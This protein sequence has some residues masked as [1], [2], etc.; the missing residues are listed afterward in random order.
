MSLIDYFAIHIVPRMYRGKGA[1]HPAP[2][3]KRT[4]V[5]SCV[6]EYDVNIFFLRKGDTL[7]AIDAGYKSHPGLL[8]RCRISA[9]GWWPGISSPRRQTGHRRQE[10][11]AMVGWPSPS[12]LRGSWCISL[13]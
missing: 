7:I 9:S 6:R 11:P 12:P 10:S 8:E 5:V 4:D 13:R 1:L 2:T 3:G